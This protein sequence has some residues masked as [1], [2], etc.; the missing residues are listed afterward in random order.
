MES[1]IEKL[2][3]ELKELKGFV[4]TISTNQ[5]PQSFQGLNY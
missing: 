5:T 2:E 3:E 1:P 4:T